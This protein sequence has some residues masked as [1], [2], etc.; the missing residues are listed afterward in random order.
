M[1]VQKRRRSTCTLPISRGARHLQPTVRN[2]AT[3][4]DGKGTGTPVAQSPFGPPPLIAVGCRGPVKVIR[5][6]LD[7]PDFAVSGRLGPR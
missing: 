2:E 4:A 7:Y 5:V 1:P 6:K 3:V